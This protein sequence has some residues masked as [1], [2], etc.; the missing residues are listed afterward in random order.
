MA[1]VTQSITNLFG[2]VSQA[3]A[4]QRDSSQFAA[5]E[6]ALPIEGVR[7]GRRPPLI[8]VAKLSPGTL[9]GAFVHS[10]GDYTVVIQG[11][12]VLVFETL[13]GIAQTVVNNVTWSYLSGGTLKAVTAGDTV[14]VV[15]TSKVV[16]KSATLPFP[17]PHRAHLSVMAGD[18]ETTYKVVVG[19]TTFTYTTPAAT[20]V[21]AKAAITTDKIAAALQV[22]I[23]P[24]FVTNADGFNVRL[25][26]S[27]LVID[28]ADAADFTID[29]TDG[30]ANEGLKL[31]KDTAKTAADLPSVGLPTTRIKVIG[32]SG[33]NVDDY[34]VELQ[35]NPNMFL[36]GD[37]WQEITDPSQ[38]HMLDS[39]TLPVRIVRD[40]A[41]V[42]TVDACPWKA[43][44]AGDDTTNPFPSF[45]GF[46][47]SDLFIYQG[48]LGFLSRDKAVLSVAGD[49]FNLFRTSAIQIRSDDPIDVSASVSGVTRLDW[50]V[51]WNEGLYLFA[52]G[53]AQYILSGA[54]DLTSSSVHLEKASDYRYA[55]GVR[56]FV[57]GHR[58]FFV[59]LKSGLPHV[60]DYHLRSEQKLHEA[61]DLG[62]HIPTYFQGDPLSLSA[63]DAQGLLL[64]RTS[65]GLY[66][67]NY[68]I[69][70][71][72]QRVQSAW[73]TWTF[74]SGE[75]LAVDL[76]NG[77]VSFVQA[78][79][80]GTY[81]NVILLDPTRL[82]IYEGFTL[83]TGVEQFDG[84]DVYD[85]G[86]G[87]VNTVTAAYLDRYV[88]TDG[89]F[90]TAVF[91]GVY[92]TWTLPYAIA[93]DG[94][95]GIVAV[96]AAN[97]STIITTTRPS[98]TTVRATGDYTLDTSRAGILYST[99]HALSTLYLRNRNTGE[100][101]TRGRLQLRWLR[102]H[103]VDTS[104]LVV[105]VSAP[106]TVDRSYSATFTYP[107][108][109]S[110]LVPLQGRNEDLS[111]VIRA[112]AAGAEAI[113]A[114]DWEGT[115]Y[116]RAARL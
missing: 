99:Q 110:L 31:I 113:S 77:V 37:T 59:A 88:A 17:A 27:V 73:N 70:E 105:T 45:T 20:A 103:Y 50:G 83:F 104:A 67:F 107:R 41:G 54:G 91:D 53:R 95:E 87:V 116:T 18:F 81:L 32:E 63:D 112:D 64:F 29:Y 2:G 26:G 80:D 47:I 60:M 96:T 8:H 40:G 74:A 48:R 46:T 44:A 90:L 89:P 34:W 16:A 25:I 93:V 109:G 75:V 84:T 19:P 85:G 49:L 5:Q 76:S 33:T 68:R 13:T 82:L 61:D 28:R 23:C 15:N 1:L 35:P 14:Y 115:Y 43:R 55:P 58:M 10:F 106:G 36:A 100:A 69:N 11:D 114:L 39:H 97:P 78:Y 42:F 101:D 94:S 62:L 102:V 98:A 3:P 24:G 56:P 9:T 51:N 7:L 86:D 57:T 30:L 38:Q 21:G 92:T 4:E 111:I 52:D 71:D 66:C 79:P 22:L 65:A 12:S 108:S 6:N 72:A